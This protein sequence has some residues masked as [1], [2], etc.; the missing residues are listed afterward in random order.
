[1]NLDKIP[2]EFHSFIPLI[3]K[4]GIYDEFERNEKIRTLNK[5]E[6]AHLAQS[7]NSEKGDKLLEWLAEKSEDLELSCSDEYINIS[8]FAMAYEY[9]R[10][11]LKS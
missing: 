11:K 8:C 1:M 4:W 6:L 9:A 3:K 7:L 10:V 2:I 5:K